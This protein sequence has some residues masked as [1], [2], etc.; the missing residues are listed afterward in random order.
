MPLDIPVADV[1]PFW[2][3]EIGWPNF[4]ARFIGGAAIG[5]SGLDAANIQW[6]SGGGSTDFMFLKAGHIAATYA[7]HRAG[8]PVGTG[9]PAMIMAPSATFASG[10]HWGGPMTLNLNLGSDA[11]SRLEFAD[12]SEITRIFWD[13]FYI[14]MGLGNDSTDS[15]IYY[16]PVS[17]ATDPG[18]TASSSNARWGFR[19]DGAGGFEF[20]AFNGVGLT[21]L[22]PFTWPASANNEW[23]KVDILHFD[24]T[25]GSDAFLQMFVNNGLV[26]TRSWGAGTNLPIWGQSVDVSPTHIIRVVVAGTVP[27]GPAWFMA[28][29]RC[30]AGIFNNTGVKL[31]G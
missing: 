20:V 28:R 30:R 29:V 19:S 10:Y 8:G 18:V 11:T 31:L 27:S 4:D 17:G 24:A 21:I 2:P 3:R 15:G 22:S 1:L 9:I 14:S 6:W 13:Q 7:I 23:A 26:Q 12:N 5:G 25:S 16:V